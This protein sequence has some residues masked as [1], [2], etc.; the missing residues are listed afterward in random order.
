MRPLRFLG[1][2]ISSYCWKVAIALRES[3]L[4]YEESL[5][6]LADPAARERFV[7]ELSPMGKIPVLVDGDR[8]IWETSIALE[9]LAD[10]FPAAAW[11]RPADPERA[12]EVR[13]WDRFFDLYVQIVGDRLRPA[14]E[15][16]ALGV[17]QAREQLRGACDVVE[18]RISG[19]AWVGDEDFTMA[20]CAAAPAL[21][22]ADRVA[23]LAERFPRTRAYLRRLVER[24]SFRRVLAD[25][26]P[27]AH[28]FPRGE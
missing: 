16:D 9:Y 12:R 21:Y 24:P 27:Y 7:R 18:R 4:A 6:D 17:A 28:L 10:T 5:V 20:D 15:R 2:P 8:A 19:R 14:G 11:L 22:Y 23:P 3:G 1:H 13:L 26:E 25:A